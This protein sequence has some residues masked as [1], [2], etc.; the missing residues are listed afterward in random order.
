MVVG[1]LVGVALAVIA[2]TWFGS[3]EPQ[4]ARPLETIPA[5]EFTATGRS[6]PA[7]PRPASGTDILP[8]DRTGG[9]TLILENIGGLDA[10]VALGGE[11]TY[12]RAVYVRSGE[13]VTV[14]NVAA[15]TYEVLMMLG[16]GWSGTRFTQEATYQQ[17]EQPIAFAE[18]DLGTTT[19]FTRLTISIQ[20]TVDGPT[21]VRETEPFLVVR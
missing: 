10:V 7:P 20:P 21:G 11:T 5:S 3:A 15:G 13:R 12:S 14:P 9:G 16:Q 18:R 1:A 4:E 2:A 8:P 17:I 19:E 6:L